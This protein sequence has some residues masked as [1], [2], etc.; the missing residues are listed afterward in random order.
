V[1]GAGGG[2]ELSVVDAAAE[3]FLGVGQRDGEGWS[4]GV[5]EF[6][7][8]G[9]AA[10]GQADVGDDGGPPKPPPPSKRPHP[11]RRLRT[12]AATWSRSCRNSRRCGTPER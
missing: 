11:S 4:F 12:Q 7:A 2:L 5:F 6:D 3:A 1:S 10:V 9:V 8:D